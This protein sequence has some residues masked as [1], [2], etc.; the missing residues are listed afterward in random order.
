MIYH[1][2]FKFRLLTSNVTEK[3]PFGQVFK[4]TFNSEEWWV[5]R[6]FEN[7]FLVLFV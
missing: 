4:N 1:L 6:Y 3:N 2:I 7:R 5:L